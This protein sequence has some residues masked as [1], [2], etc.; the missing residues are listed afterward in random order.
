MEPEIR[1]IEFDPFDH[2]GCRFFDTPDLIHVS[3]FIIL[4]QSSL[5]KVNP[6]LMLGSML[7]V[8]EN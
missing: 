2:Y 6:D 5:L 7:A 8:S 4:L 3:D 1:F